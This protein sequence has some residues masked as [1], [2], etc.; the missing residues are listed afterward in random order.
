[1]K[2]KIY[3]KTESDKKVFEDS[4]AKKIFES[5]EI[6]FLVKNGN[7]KINFNI[8]EKRKNWMNKENY[9]MKMKKKK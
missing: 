4:E 8:H 6:L 1:M 7:N 3:I 5:M 2:I 9:L